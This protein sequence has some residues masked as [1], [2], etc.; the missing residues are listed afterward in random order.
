MDVFA[1]IREMREQIVKTMQERGVTELTTVMSYKQWGKKKEYS[2]EDYQE[3][4]DN[5]FDYAC[6]KDEEAPY[7]IFFDKYSMGRCYRVDKVILK[8]CPGGDP[9][10]ELDCYED[11]VGC[12]TFGEDDVV[13]L[14]LYYVYDALLDLLEMG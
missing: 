1:I 12:D 5:D 2:D 3:D 6:Y 7:V 8:T 11:E 9:V 4:E 13:F 14:S 10:L